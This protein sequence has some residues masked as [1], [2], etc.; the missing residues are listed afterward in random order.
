MTPP[1]VGVSPRLDLNRLPVI[2][3]DVG[4]RMTGQDAPGH[5]LEGLRPRRTSP[6]TRRSERWPAPTCWGSPDRSPAAGATLA[7]RA[8]HAGESA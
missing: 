6:D 2:L 7:V 8:G 1:S 3:Q 5:V 4:G